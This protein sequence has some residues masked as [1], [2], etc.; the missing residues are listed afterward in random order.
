MM[1]IGAFLGFIVGYQVSTFISETKKNSHPEEIF[2]KIEDEEYRES[3]VTSD[4]FREG[5][6]DEE[7][8][9]INCPLGMNDGIF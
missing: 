9:N 1:G 8:Q 2:I 3:M 7:L 5:V 4:G 6:E